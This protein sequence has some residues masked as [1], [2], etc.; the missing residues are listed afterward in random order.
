MGVSLAIKR[1][2]KVIYAFS[3]LC[4]ILA[5]WLFFYGTD[6]KGFGVAVLL[7]ISV[8]AGIAGWIIDGLA[9]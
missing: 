4:V 7:V 5:V 6:G 9:S 3:G 1:L 2:S 8:L